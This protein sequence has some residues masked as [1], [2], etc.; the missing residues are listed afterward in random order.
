M[1]M[2][3][4]ESGASTV[5]SI[6]WLCIFLT[7][8]G[9]V[10]D[11]SNAFRH[12][13]ALQATADASSLA[14]IITY[15]EADKFASTF[16]TVTTPP[17]TASA[18]GKA[19][20]NLLA[21]VNMDP[22][23]NVTSV[24]PETEVTMGYWNGSAFIAE[25]DFG[26]TGLVV[27]AAKARALR[28]TS[29]GNPLNLL[30]VD[31]F[32]PADA[33]DVGATAIA[34]MFEPENCPD[35][36]GVMAGG[37]L[38][39]R[40]NNVFQGSICLH[41][42][43]RVIF[44][45]NSGHYPADDGTYPTISYGK[46][47]DGL[48]LGEGSRCETESP[49]ED[50]I[51]RTSDI[52]DTLVGDGKLLEEN[53]IGEQ[54]Y[55]PD[56]PAIYDYYIAAATN[57]KAYLSHEN[58]ES[59]YIPQAFLQESSLARNYNE[60]DAELRPAPILDASQ[61]PQTAVID[62]TV[63]PLV[64]GIT[65]INMTADNFQDLVDGYIPGTTNG[66]SSPQN[67]ESLPAGYRP[68]PERVVVSIDGGI[69]G[70]CSLSGNQGIVFAN[71]LPFNNVVLLS[72]CGFTFNGTNDLSGSSIMSSALLPGGGAAIAGNSGAILGNGSCDDPDRRFGTDIVANGNISM[73]AGVTIR[74]SRLV[75]KSNVQLAAQ[76]DAFQGSQIIADGDVDIMAGGGWVGCEGGV[77]GENTL[78]DNYYRL[79]Y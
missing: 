65:Q 53:I 16:P 76:G 68:L 11:T 1:S 10:I 77:N 60:V 30:L 6:F 61:V 79:V 49:Y 47:A 56:V 75:T 31:I 41:G 39:F 34:Q 24:T 15:K 58:A 72:P 36:E 9:L 27:N 37:T 26:A 13:A 14:A 64:H 48:C 40:S 4:D 78:V 73:A 22:G 46:D 66:G 18:R 35:L 19:A 57:P 12:K 20:G 23:V 42:E 70:T 17:A 25:A 69:N 52:S 62:P 55:M 7:I 2:R 51:G 8:A 21:N 45:N 33:W 59:R 54:S 44:Q 5:W 74:R 3:N 67:A 38:F 29:N 71:D 32:G 28:T 50:A 43:D 63:D